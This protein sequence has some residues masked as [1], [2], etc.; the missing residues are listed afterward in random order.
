[1]IVNVDKY[2]YHSGRQARLR[3]KRITLLAAVVVALAAG[4]A[5]FLFVLPLI[6]G[7]GPGSPDVDIVGLWNGGLYDNVISVCRKGLTKDPMDRD[8]LMFYGFAKYYKAFYEK[9]LEDKIPLLDEAVIS[10][11]R[12]Q[13]SPGLTH[14]GQAY[15][16]LGQVYYH[17][18]RF[19][20]DLAA[21][22]LELSLEYGYSG[23]ETYEYLGL[24]YGGLG[25]PEKEL[26]YFLKAVKQNPTDL[27]LLS[28]GKAHFKLKNFDAAVGFLLRSINKTQDG[29]VEKECRL[30]LAEIYFH[31]DDLLEAE[32]Q[33]KAI[34][35]LD[36]NSAV[37]HFQLGE[38]YY[39]M[40]NIVEARAEWRKTLAIDPS[41][42]GAKL[43]YYK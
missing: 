6:A 36:S 13:L 12:S 16:I 4:L 8:L 2:R 22:Y 26:E 27:I 19:Y 20:F 7:Q 11:R 23:R 24:A 28:A 35:A 3:R 30:K 40:S 1:M 37:A 5:F 34:V 29:D 15:Y 39:Q 17:K 21:K 41:H 33:Y 18:G 25:Q 31:M 38:I 9:A 10:L 43:R 32:A 14:R 42:Y